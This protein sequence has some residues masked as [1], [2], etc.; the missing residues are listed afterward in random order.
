M[1]TNRRKEQR[2][3][4][5]C[6][7]LKK[8]ITEVEESNDVATLALT[9]TNA[10]IRRLRLEYAILLERLEERA[11]NPAFDPEDMSPPPSPKILDESLNSSNV[12]LNKG[13]SGVKRGS[14]K[15]GGRAGSS[16]AG[17]NGS[18]GASSKPAR[19]P[20]LP[21]RPTNAYLIFCDMEKD[22]IRLELEEKNPGAVS[23]L[24]KAITEAWN[25]LNE[26]GRAPYFKLYQDD[27]ERYHREMSIY[28]QRKQEAGEAETPA[29]KRQKFVIKLKPQQPQVQSS[30]TPVANDE[31]KVELNSEIDP[32]SD[33]N[34][35]EEPATDAPESEFNAPEEEGT[36][37]EEVEEGSDPADDKETDAKEIKDE[38]KEVENK[39]D[40]TTNDI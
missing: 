2:F 38:V 10:V 6:R 7:E 9:R 26:E 33:I 25:N 1:A 34:D 29:P 31:P 30:P 17:S 12:K 16:V 21:K 19:D 28:N 27:R 13:G 20:N 35:A 4:Q 11:T 37:M 14:R 24:S 18:S 32:P 39:E 40:E 5:K 3:K 8:R 36:P 23:E 22:R 15:A